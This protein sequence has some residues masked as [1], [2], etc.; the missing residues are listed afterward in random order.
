MLDQEQINLNDRTSIYLKFAL[1]IRR[2][3]MKTKLYKSTPSNLINI[4]IA[5]KDIPFCEK[6]NGKLNIINT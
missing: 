5:K 6:K 4:K 1:E 2:S 3:K